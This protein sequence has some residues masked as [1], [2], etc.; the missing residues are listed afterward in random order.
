MNRKIA[1]RRTAGP[2]FRTLRA[3]RRL[4]G[5]RFDPFGLAEVR[6]VERSLI[7]EYRSTVTGLL[8]DLSADT[9]PR[10]VQIAGLPDMIRGYEDIKLASVERYREALRSL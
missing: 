2:A 8:R 10:A 7:E 9:L 1:L 5:T 3:M 6:R 4:R